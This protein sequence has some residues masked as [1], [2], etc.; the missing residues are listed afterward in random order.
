MVANN[1]H[2]PPSGIRVSAFNL[3]IMWLVHLILKANYTTQRMLL[4]TPLTYFSPVQRLVKKLVFEL[5]RSKSQD[6]WKLQL[7]VLYSPSVI[8]I[9]IFKGEDL[10]V[11]TITAQ[12]PPVFCLLFFTFCVCGWGEKSFLFITGSFRICLIFFI[13]WGEN[14]PQIASD[15][16]NTT[17]NWTI[18]TEP[19]RMINTIE[20]TTQS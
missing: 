2:A 15:A 8:F 18:K 3:I 4:L 1:P 12:S 5:V 9:R 14:I 19:Y 16:N 10:S 20:L 13:G 17:K 6:I 11:T 7:Y